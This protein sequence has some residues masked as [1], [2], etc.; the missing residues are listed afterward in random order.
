MTFLF[1]VMRFSACILSAAVCVATVGCGGGGSVHV[2][3]V[4]GKVTYQ[5]QPLSGAFV[6][7]IPAAFDPTAPVKKGETV[8]MERPSGETDDEGGYELQYGG[9][10]GA[11]PGKYKVI[12]IAM[13]EPSS[14]ETDSE[15][16]PIRPSL[17][18]AKYGN[19]N[20]SQL[21]ADVKEDGDNVFNFPLQ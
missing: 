10:S 15:G 9:K 8:S 11:P 14:T 16:E 3:P 1:S 12:I 17:I 19:P 5:N 4:T 20:L 7:F 21:A 13:G 18:P 2:V 6:T